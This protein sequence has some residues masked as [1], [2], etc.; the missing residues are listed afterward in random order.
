[1]RAAELSA[2][3]G[4]AGVLE[5]SETER[6]LIRAAVSLDCAQGEV[7][8]QGAQ[9]TYWQPQGARP[10]LFTSP[11]SS[12]TP[13]HAIRGGVPV[14]FPWFGPKADAP[15]APQHG[16]ARI[17]PWRLEAVEADGRARLT[18]SFALGHDD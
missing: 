9:V 12:F 1:M 15:A 10:V 14:I 18:L 16:F 5:F 17:A 3:F 7:F 6:G 4:I 8:L 11:N 13:D 2:E